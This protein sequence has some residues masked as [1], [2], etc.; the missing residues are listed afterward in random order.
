MVGPEHNLSN[1][2]KNA[3]AMQNYRISQ[4][5]ASPG[6]ETDLLR[7]GADLVPAL[8][9][10]WQDTLKK[11]LGRNPQIS[12]DTVTSEYI[13]HIEPV[14][15]HLKTIQRCTLSARI[16]EQGE[17]IIRYSQQFQTDV[18]G[19]AVYQALKQGQ[20]E[21][22][23]PDDLFLQAIDQALLKNTA[24]QRSVDLQGDQLTLEIRWAQADD[25]QAL[26][27]LKA[28]GIGLVNLSSGQP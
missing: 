22:T 4:Y 13:K 17:R 21:I 14:I 2:T 23:N 11:E 26:A 3:K 8:Y 10:N 12:A 6:T 1:L 16:T 20:L 5:A 28:T 24:L 18:D 25:Q 19:S 27:N 7:I 9:E 15:D